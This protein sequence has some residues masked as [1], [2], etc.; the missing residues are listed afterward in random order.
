M[1]IKSKIKSLVMK[2]MYGYSNSEEY[3]NWL[4]NKGATVGEG[5]CFYS[6]NRIKID[7][8]RAYGV[9]IGK[10]VHITAD[11]SILTHGFDWCVVK[12]LYDD[13]VGSFGEVT[14][15]DNC[16]IGQGTRILKGVSI[17][18]NT[19]IGAGSLVS[20]SLPRSG[21]YVGN[22]A[23]FICSVEEYYEKRKC[24]QI[25]E[26]KAQIICYYKKYGK[27]PPKSELNEFFFLFEDRSLELEKKFKHQM[28]NNQRY[29]ECLALYLS[30]HRQEFKC[31]EEFVEY[32]LKDEEKE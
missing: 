14:I 19:I 10:N 2:M 17:P 7:I 29:E 16:F 3:A 6:P 5:T 27:I 8:S 24:A 22:P 13:V 28:R 25:N 31:Y 26:A 9:T 1:S 4:R 20:K 18:D 15:G 32:C 30:G 11:V 12:G 21:V 23:K